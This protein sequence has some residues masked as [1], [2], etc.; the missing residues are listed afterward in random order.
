[1]AAQRYEI[2]LRVLNYFASEHS[3]QVKYFQHEKRNFVSPSGHKH[4][5]FFTLLVFAVKGAIYYMLFPHV[6]EDIMF[7]R[8]S[9]LSILLVFIQ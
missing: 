1:M 5:T 3:E 6:R 8:E 2:S 7:S 4:P 9:S